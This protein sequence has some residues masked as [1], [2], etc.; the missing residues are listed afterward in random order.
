M[1]FTIRLLI[2]GILPPFL[3]IN[4]WHS[5][6][7]HLELI[8]LKNIQKLIRNNPDQT[9]LNTIQRSLHLIHSLSLYTK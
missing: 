7:D 1:V 4:K 3:Q 6:Q 2:R 8:G 5:I 9:P